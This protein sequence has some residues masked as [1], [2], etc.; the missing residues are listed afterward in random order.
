MKMR[1]RVANVLG[2]RRCDFYF[3]C[4]I[5]NFDSPVG[6]FGVYTISVNFTERTGCGAVM[7]VWSFPISMPSVWYTIIN[8]ACC[9]PPNLKGKQDE[10]ILFNEKYKPIR[11]WCQIIDRINLKKIG[12]LWTSRMSAYSITSNTELPKLTHISQSCMQVS[13]K[14]MWLLGCF[15]SWQNRLPALVINSS[16]RHP[17]TTINQSSWNRSSTF[18]P[19]F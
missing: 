6:L 19:S 5:G 7:L 11:R 12:W 4:V 18:S 2:A 1:S 3:Y 13:K 15:F 9:T 14:K 8:I 17:K 16:N 10:C